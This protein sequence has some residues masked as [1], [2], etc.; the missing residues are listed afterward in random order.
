M[1]SCVTEYH[2]AELPSNKRWGYCVIM[3]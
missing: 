1:M 3:N 2:Q